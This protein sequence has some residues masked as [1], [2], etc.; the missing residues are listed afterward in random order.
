MALCARNM[1][2]KKALKLG[3][4]HEK[5]N[6]LDFKKGHEEEGILPDKSS[7]EMD[8]WNNNKGIEI[9]EKYK[10]ISKDSLKNI[11]IQALQ[12]GEMKIIKTNFQGEYLDCNGN[13]IEISNGK[14][15]NEKCL[16]PSNYRR[17]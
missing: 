17:K 7:M 5:G 16:V 10:N 15:D 6:Y 3:K 8:L 4:A 2:S 1:K 11:I 12:Q 9:S 14:W 13:K